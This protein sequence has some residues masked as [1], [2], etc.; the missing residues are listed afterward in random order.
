MSLDVYLYFDVDVGHDEHEEH[1]VYSAN[2]THNLNRMASEAGIY[3]CLWRP[4]EHGIENAEQIIETLSNG[5]DDMLQR[6]AHYRTFDSP[7]RW[8]VYENFVP[9]CQEYLFAC[10]KYPKARIRVSR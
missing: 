4:D 1:V 3:E 10:K 6:P 5:V 7:N 8:G 2:I 9:W